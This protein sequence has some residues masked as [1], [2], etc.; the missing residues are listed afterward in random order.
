MFFPCNSS[1][2]VCTESSI[3]DMSRFFFLLHQWCEYIWWMQIRNGRTVVLLLQLALIISICFFWGVEG[4]ILLPPQL[5]VYFLFCGMGSWY[6]NDHIRGQGSLEGNRKSSA[7]LPLSGWS[8]HPSCRKIAGKRA[9]R[10][11]LNN[12]SMFGVF[13]PNYGFLESLHCEHT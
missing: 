11:Y 7:F 5:F 6:C 4:Q 9:Y 1:S 8:C 10:S 13:F 3:T 2:Q 12:F